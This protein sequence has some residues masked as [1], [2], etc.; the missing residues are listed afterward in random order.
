MKPLARC[1]TPKSPLYPPIAPNAVAAG[2]LTLS[3]PRAVT[4]FYDL[5][6]PVTLSRLD[7]GEGVPYIGRAGSPISI[8][9]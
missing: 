9:C 5:D 2:E 7:C 3:S 1:R 6:T 8:W 4:V